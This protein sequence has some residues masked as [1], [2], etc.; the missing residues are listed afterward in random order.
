MGGR[1]KRVRVRGNLAGGLPCD[2]SVSVKEQT[3]RDGDTLVNTGVVAWP[4]EDSAWATVRRMQL[5]LHRWASEDSARRFEWV[6]V[7]RRLQRHRDPLP[8]PRGEH[9]DPLDRHRQRRLSNGQDTWRAGCVETRTSGSAGGHG[10]RT[11]GNPDT[12]PVP[13]LTTTTRRFMFDQRS[14]LVSDAGPTSGTPQAPHK[15]SGVMRPVWR[16]S[17]DAHI[18][19]G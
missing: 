5:K 6:R 11:R 1:R 18:G 7:H 14:P 19:S 3:A 17:F 16:G 15:R 8:L 2:G 10:K 12:A 9:P 13:D 4:D